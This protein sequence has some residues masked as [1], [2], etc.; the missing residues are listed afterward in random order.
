MTDNQKVWT[1]AK[2]ELVSAIQSLGFP[3]EFGEIMAKQLGSPKAMDRM[4]AY[5]YMVKPRNEELIADEM[6][7][8]CDDINRWKDKK[9]TEE[10]NARYN[11]MLN[12][13]VQSVKK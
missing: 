1:Q 6:L 12:L 11:E 10:A 5:L 3:E 13:S 9:L 8:I 4:T 2:N 7:A